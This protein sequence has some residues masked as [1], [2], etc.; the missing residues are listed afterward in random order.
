MSD[1]ELVINLIRELPESTSLADIAKDV[2][3]LAA[4]REAE[5][6]ADRGQ[7]VA[8]EDLKRESATWRAK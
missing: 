2:E 6:E 8:H 3:F 5:A 4:I 7:V 1:K